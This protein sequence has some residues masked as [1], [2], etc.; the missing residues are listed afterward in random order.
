MLILDAMTGIAAAKVAAQLAAI[1]KS[2]V[3]EESPL[4]RLPLAKQAAEL[5]RQLTGGATADDELSDDPNS[6]NYRYR[7]TG[8][9][10]GSR[11][12][13]AAEMIRTARTN[14]RAVLAN[15][16][17]WEE[18][19]RN[20]RAATEL[21]TKS[22]LFGK[23][24]WDALKAGGM[25]PG[26]AFLIDRVYAS[27]G[28]QPAKDGPMGRRDY[29]M[30]LENIRA[31]LEKAITPQDVTDI[32]DEIAA[33]L[34]GSQLNAE[35]SD[36]YTELKTKAG[37][38][39]QQYLDLRKPLEELTGKR[40][41]IMR[42]KNEAEWERDRRAKRGW[43]PDPALDAKL[44]ELTEQ[45]E[46]A[47][48]DEDAYKIANPLA[49]D[50][51][52][53]VQEGG[54][55]GG[56]SI[57]R[58]EKNP[59]LQEM[60]A[61]RKQADAVVEYA[62][63]RNITESPITRGWL[64]FGERFFAAINYR[65]HNGSDAFASHVTNAK[66]GRIKDWDWAE[67]ERAQVKQATKR[68]QRFQMRVAENFTRRGG[69]PVS[70]KSTGEL[71]DLIGLRDIQ[72]GNWVLDDPN[73]AKWHIE[74]AAAAMLDLSDLTGINENALGLGGRLAIAFG[75]RGKGNTGFGGAA[76]AHYEPVQRVINITKMRGGGALAHEWFH[77]VD[78]LIGELM[79]GPASD[80]KTMGTLG[81]ENIPPGAVRDAINEVSKII[82]QG[83]RR[84]G[85]TFKIDSKMRQ[86][87]KSNVGRSG[88]AIATSIR[89]AKDAASAV[90]AVDR[91]FERYEADNKKAQKNRKDWRNIA[92]AHHTPEG[93]DE[94]TLP[95]GRP[96]SNFW[97]EAV[98]LDGGEVGKYWSERDEM[99][100]RAFQ[101]YVEDKLAASG[102]QNDYLSALADNKYH[103]DP[104][105]GIEW[106]PFPEG[107]ERAR[108]NAAFDRLFDAIR[109][110][111]VFE[112]ATANKA[113]LDSIFG[114]E[115]GYGDA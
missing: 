102:R 109:K 63:Y 98:I 33:E 8:Y 65:R 106:K 37:E 23:T 39:R 70:V 7:D 20:P 108:F 47:S 112:K 72:S 31:R 80:K 18:V 34:T 15:Q 91:H 60:Y 56:V 77:S 50:D 104:M 110:E 30:A 107:E 24:D 41:A 96:G 9:I 53:Y 44:A 36:R 6:P 85:E 86:L 16:I 26:T 67:K 105:F 114:E 83:D 4:K 3:A 99:A 43:K 59:L 46:M 51:Y 69:R 111:Q 78:N 62:K 88:S 57:R 103:V 93:Q 87:A 13:Q 61:L 97:A 75:A 29:A 113:L 101:A 58:V 92:V 2:L 54:G 10:A 115:N 71:K 73:S 22:N 82:A 17:D 5:I 45:Y 84:L 90:L 64:T 25:E 74:N 19:E 1:T 66:A 21:I 100:A 48:A 89:E 12:E 55:I 95:T 27:I 68:E 94:I 14:G 32:L 38:L 35:E 49:L 79:G 76:S 81:A 40:M 42:E 28:P 52:E 11:K